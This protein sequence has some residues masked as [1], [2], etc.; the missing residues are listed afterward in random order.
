[1]PDVPHGDSESDSFT[2]SL[3]DMLE[4]VSAA[5]R[6]EQEARENELRTPETR[7]ARTFTEPAVSPAAAQAAAA[8]RTGARADA[9]T[10]LDVNVFG[11]RQRAWGVVGVVALGAVVAW[12]ALRCGTPPGVQL[13]LE[14]LPPT[15]AGSPSSATATP[16]APAP[17]A[18]ASMATPNIAPAIL[19]AIANDAD[20]STEAIML[21]QLR[22]GSAT[23]AATEAPLFAIA[24]YDSLPAAS[25]AWRVLVPLA[26]EEVYALV[27]ATSRLR[28]LDDLRGR[29]INIGV[30][31]SPRAR[32]AEALYRT[33]FGQP[34][35]PSLLRAAPKEVALPALLRGERLDAMLLFDGQPSSWLAA[36]PVETRLRLKVLRFDPT[37]SPGI[38]TALRPAWRIR[39]TTSRA[40]A[41]AAARPM[42]ESPPVINALRPAS[43]P[44]PT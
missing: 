27:P 44:D 39:S 30:A 8:T 26:V 7:T 34:V 41:M 6:A 31:A 38:A 25:Q 19:P 23:S 21:E 18:V 17:V 5:T 40:Y 4:R 9:T 1:M 33:L 11:I 12:T 16:A 36:L 13:T 20:A 43:R 22:A 15:A 29:R 42:P 32:S 37:R 2:S 28:E 14:N 3:D 24:R 35:P 10:L